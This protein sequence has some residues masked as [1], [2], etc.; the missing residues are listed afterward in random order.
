MTL[1]NISQNKRKSAILIF[2]VLAI[3]CFLIP[4]F[5]VFGSS[6]E[7]NLDNVVIKEY[8]NVGNEVTFADATINV[9]GKDYTVKP[10][11]KYPDGSAQRKNTFT[12]D[13]LGKYSI[14]YEIK[15]GNDTY[16]EEKGFVV[17]D[18]LF[19][20]SATG[21]GFA[22]GTNH[23]SNVTKALSSILKLANLCFTIKL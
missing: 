12:L 19:S 22:Y 21:E 11:V 17:Y 10:T 5:T 8:Y 15:V 9:G 7:M 3:I 23:K 1:K 14:V 6:G 4:A 18:Y 16:R 20:N 2:A 13:Q